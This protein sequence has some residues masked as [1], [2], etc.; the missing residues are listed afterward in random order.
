MA[1]TP[2]HAELTGNDRQRS[3]T[4]S[5]MPALFRA[6]QP[7]PH[8][9]L[10]PVLDIGC[11]YGGIT[12]AVGDHLNARDL[13][14]VDIDPGVIAEA[15]NKGIQAQRVDVESEPIPYP[16]ETFDLAFS[17]GMLDYLPTFD[18][19]FLEVN[20]VLAA[21]GF[22][23]FSIPNLGSWHNRLALLLGYQPRDVEVS[24]RAVVGTMP[25]YKGDQPAGHLHTATL[26]AFRELAELHGF[27]EVAVTG[28]SWATRKT[29]KIALAIDGLFAR[30]PSLSRRYFFLGRKSGPPA[31]DTQAGWWKGRD[32]LRG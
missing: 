4:A 14:G 30:L 3:A 13:H 2:Y 11:G 9:S 32:A 19:L 16:D 25:H 7:V 27:T 26:R 18:G 28:G 23:L 21:D 6:L 1:N 10:G 22:V 8:S 20:R 24:D 12:R 29:P 5:G 31:M 17:L 15:S